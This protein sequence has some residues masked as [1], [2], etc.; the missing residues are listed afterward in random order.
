MKRIIKLQLLPL[1]K[2]ENE[3]YLH[4]SGIGINVGHQLIYSFVITNFSQLSVSSTPINI[5]FPIIQ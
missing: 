1:K 4:D 5:L 3:P 2:K